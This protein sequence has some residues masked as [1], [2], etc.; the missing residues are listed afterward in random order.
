[1]SLAASDAEEWGGSGREPEV[2]PPS[3]TLR[4]DAELIHVL[5]K[6]GRGSGLE[7]AALT[8]A[9][10]TTVDGADDR[11]YIKLPPLEKAVATHMCPPSALGLKAHAA[12]PS[13]PCRTTS[14]L[15]NMAYAAAGQAGSAQHTMAVLQ[16]FQAKLLHG[17]DE[18]GQV[19]Q[20]A[21]KELRTATDLALR[22]MK[23][24]PQAIGKDYG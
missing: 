11:G 20:E 24:M 4:P 13:E 23:A 15:A 10:L 18:S 8:A 16:V 19:H 2:L 22:T 1:M 7:A 9:A 12:H 3:Q 17:M 21:F 14:A 5:S 6:A